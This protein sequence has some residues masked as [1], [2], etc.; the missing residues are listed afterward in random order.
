MAITAPQVRHWNRDEYINKMA[1]AGVFAPGERVELIEGEI[2]AV[3]PQKSPHAAAVRLV[4]GALRGVFGGGFDVRPQLPLG[5]GPDSEPEPEIAVVRGTPRDYVQEHPTTAILLVEV[6]DATLEFD[7]GRKASL[8]A[9]AGIPE[10]WVVNL[11]DRTL[12]VHRDPGPLPDRP[13]G[14]GYRSIR[15]IGPA[16]S[17]APASAPTAQV[18]VVDL[19]P[20]APIPS[21]SQPATF[22]VSPRFAC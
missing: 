10:Y 5:L 1:E 15:R 4:Q 8:Y 3:T 13:S 20:E 2:I 22:F 14:Y 12:E 9:R 7:R 21:T 18:H 19:C 17:V 6:A 11:P 16:E